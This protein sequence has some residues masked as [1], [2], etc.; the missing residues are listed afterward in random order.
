MFWKKSEAEKFIE[1]NPWTDINRFIAYFIAHGVPFEG[2]YSKEEIERFAY[3]S[4][5]DLKPN[6]EVLG[7]NG[8]CD[9]IHFDK[10][11]GTEEIRKNIKETIGRCG[12]DSI[13]VSMSSI[14]LKGGQPFKNALTLQ[15]Y[16]VNVTVRDEDESLRAIVFDQR[17][18]RGRIEKKASLLWQSHAIREDFGRVEGYAQ[19]PKDMEYRG[20]KIEWNGKDNNEPQVPFV[21]G[22][23]D[24]THQLH[25]YGRKIDTIINDRTM[26][27][28]LQGIRREAN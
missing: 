3:E 8:D 22:S 10:I 26:S 27:E 2:V 19:D 25:R 12:P 14:V 18:K 7:V 15:E 4:K 13:K 9:Y 20:Y 1:R 5:R 28:I 17:N 6:G 16:G 24:H 21:L 11:I 23:N